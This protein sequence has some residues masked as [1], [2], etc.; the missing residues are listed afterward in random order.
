MVYMERLWI[1]RN[2]KARLYMVAV[3]LTMTHGCEGWYFDERAQ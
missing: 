2:M 1:S 3:Q